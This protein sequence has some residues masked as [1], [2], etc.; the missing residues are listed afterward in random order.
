MEEY[1][2][3]CPYCGQRISMSLDLSV[4]PHTYIEDCEVCCNP[5]EVTYYASGQ[6]VT[7]FSARA[8]DE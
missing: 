1:A 4:S 2:F 6:R 5:I 7:Q 3:I 8:T